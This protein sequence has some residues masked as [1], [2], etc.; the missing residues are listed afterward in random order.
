MHKD[1]VPLVGP[2]L[3][4]WCQRWKRPWRVPVRIVAFGCLPRNLETLCVAD[5]VVEEGSVGS[6]K[7][8]L[9]G[10]AV[11]GF[12]GRADFLC[13]FE[14]RK[15]RIEIQALELLS[16]VYNDGLWQATESPDALP[17]HH[18]ARAVGGGIIGKVDGENA[19]GVRVSQC[20]QP[21]ARGFH[22]WVFGARNQ[23]DLCMIDVA[24]FER[25]IAVP[26]SPFRKPPVPWLERICMPGALPALRLFVLVTVVNGGKI[27]LI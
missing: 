24:D 26:G 22:I 18:H 14:K 13:N 10:C 1:V 3:K 7:R 12:G 5:A 21:E 20:G 2:V 19:P 9:L 8:P 17:N 6:A 25:P 27:G 15:N 11:A 16:T 4:T 23:I